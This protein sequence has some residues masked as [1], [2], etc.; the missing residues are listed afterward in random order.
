MKQCANISIIE[1][2]DPGEI[3][4]IELENAKEQLKNTEKDMARANSKIEELQ[5]QIVKQKK[6]NQLLKKVLIGAAVVIAVSV[7][8]IIVK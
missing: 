3:L 4:K 5:K 6:D 8:V 1:D 2:D 7:V